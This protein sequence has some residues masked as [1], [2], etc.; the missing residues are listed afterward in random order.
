MLKNN[1]FL[2][3]IF[4]GFRPRFGRVFERFFGLKMH[5]GSDL[6]KSVREP[7]CIGKTNTKSMSAPLQQSIF[8]A[9][10]DEKSHVFWDI[11]F[12][13]ILGRFWEGFGKPKSMIFALFSMFFRC[14]FSSAVRMAKKSSKNAKKP[15]FSAFWRRVCG[16][17]PPRWGKERIEV[18][19]LQ[20][21]MLENVEIGFL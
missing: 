7:F 8:R 12:K 21:E 19:T 11:D 18:R 4:Q 10:F 9:K 2:A 13:G 5:A 16:G 14:R 3:S 17:P 6:K 15:N 1:T 20:I